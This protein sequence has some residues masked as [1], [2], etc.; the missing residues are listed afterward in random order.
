MNICFYCKINYL[1]FYYKINVFIAKINICFYCKNKYLCF[2][3][4]NELNSFYNYVYFSNKTDHHDI[5]EILLK[6]AL[7]TI[8]LILLCLLLAAKQCTK[9]QFQ[10]DKIKCVPYMWVCDNDKDCA[11]G[12]DEPDNCKSSTCP[13]NFYKCNITG[14][15]IPY[16]WKCD[17]DI[18]CGVSDNSDEA[19]CG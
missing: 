8:T 7:N 16:S 2:Y 11:D 14:R 13:S 12:T 9:D 17:G 18:D 10:C 3:C 15:C 5:A 1:C 19:L 4:K 6:V